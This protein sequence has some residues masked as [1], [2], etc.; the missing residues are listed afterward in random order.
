MESELPGTRSGVPAD[1]KV[2]GA[3]LMSCVWGSG[4]LGIPIA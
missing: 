3:T 1:S 4:V 2:Q